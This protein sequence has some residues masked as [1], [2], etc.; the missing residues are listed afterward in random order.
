M[1]AHAQD[2]PVC[3]QS[4]QSTPPG[5]DAGGWIP[6][7]RYACRFWLPVLGPV[8]WSL[9][10]A[11]V[12]YTGDAERPVWRGLRQLARSL[13]CDW[14]TLVG[15]D[16]D[17]RH[18]PG[19]A[20][21]LEQGQLLRVAVQ[22]DGARLWWVT[23]RPPLLPA[24]AVAAL[25]EALRDEHARWVAQ[26]PEPPRRS[27]HRKQPRSA[28]GTSLQPV[29]I[30]LHP[31]GTSPPKET[32]TRRN[33]NKRAVPEPPEHAEP[34][35]VRL[36]QHW[37]VVT[38]AAGLPPGL[39]SRAYEQLRPVGVEARAGALRLSV[40]ARSTVEASRWRRYLPQLSR[41]LAELTGQPAAAVVILGP[42][43]GRDHPEP[44]EPWD[45]EEEEA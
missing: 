26:H 42:S 31:V 2:T 35:D 4:T 30:S 33:K 13:G 22:P 16:R 23:R 18:A 34:V 37:Y 10:C 36:R 8:P 12:A 11:L 27:T 15:R 6:L 21:V 29:G 41:S 38:D 3:L 40:R 45:Q 44:L 20:D 14:R 32:P 1:T 19:A 17:G 25:P 28:V 5:P 7:D 9:W 43:D 39:G 24:A